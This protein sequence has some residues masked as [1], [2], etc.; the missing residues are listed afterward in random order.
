MVVVV[1][2]VAMPV[3]AAQTWLRCFHLPAA[4][5]APHM[6]TAHHG[7]VDTAWCRRRGLGQFNGLLGRRTEVSL[8][9]STHTATQPHSHTHA[10][11]HTRTHTHTHTHTKQVSEAESDANPG[12]DS[13]HDVQTA[14]PRSSRRTHATRWTSCA[15]Q[16]ARAMTIWHDRR[17]TATQS[18]CWR[19][20][21]WTPAMPLTTRKCRW[22][23]GVGGCVLAGWGSAGEGSPRP[24]CGETRTVRAQCPQHPRTASVM[25]AGVHPRRRRRERH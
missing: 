18:P 15:A 10:H 24:C 2:P 14:F 19:R 23:A 9:M 7:T 11:T 25:S 8:H 4:T 5:V 16:S 3:V 6:A 1:L 21:Q 20:R 17:R 22:T 12:T 13:Q